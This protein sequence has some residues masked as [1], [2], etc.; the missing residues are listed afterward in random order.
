MNQTTPESEYNAT[1]NIP[2]GSII[3]YNP[4]LAEC[5]G[6]KRPNFVGLSHELSHSFDFNQGIENNT[7]LTIS[8]NNKDVLRQREIDAVI[9]ENIVRKNIGIELRSSYGGIDINEYL[10]SVQQRPPQPEGLN[11]LFYKLNKSK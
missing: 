2:T 9:R 8:Y 3:H 10:P 4:D 11:P 5:E 1:N 7:P 6:G